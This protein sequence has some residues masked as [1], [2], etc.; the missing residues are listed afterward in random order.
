ML[1][2]FLIAK[3]VVCYVEQKFGEVLAKFF[4][5]VDDTILTFPG[6]EGQNRQ[7]PGSKPIFFFIFLVVEV[8]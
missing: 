2:V 3:C 4:S 5:D 6:E 8:L 7:D 1:S